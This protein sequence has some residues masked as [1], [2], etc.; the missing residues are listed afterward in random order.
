MPWS[1]RELAE[2]A[3]TTVKTV[4]HYHRVGLLEEPGRTSNGY[5]QYGVGHLVRLLRIRRLVDLGLPLSAIGDLSD[6]SPGDSGPADAA[7]ALRSL[8]ADLAESIARQQEIR[9]DIAQILE[10]GGPPDLPTGF[11]VL[12]GRLDDADR[13]LLLVYSTVLE[14]GDLEKV[15][16]MLAD[17]DPPAEATTFRELAPDADEVTREELARTYAPKVRSQLDA[18]GLTSGIWATASHAEA[19]GTAL[20]ELYNPAQIDVL[21]RMSSLVTEPGESSGD[22]EG[23]ERES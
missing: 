6:T 18:H 22:G 15:R 21:V 16:S 1:T 4:R 3:G 7:E 23:T 10:H 12:E 11:S 19:L 17:P 9:D 14:P 2:I 5:K 8:D 20:R 13:A